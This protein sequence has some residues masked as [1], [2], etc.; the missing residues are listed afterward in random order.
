MRLIVRNVGGSPGDTIHRQ[1]D[2]DG[3]KSGQ[4]LIDMQNKKEIIYTLT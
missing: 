1:T 4:N 3:V 2:D